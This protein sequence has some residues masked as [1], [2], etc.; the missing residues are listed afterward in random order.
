M[1]NDDI[2]AFEAEIEQVTG[3][4]SG[5]A[6]AGSKLP[7]LYGTDKTDE[8]NVD[9]P[10]I[11]DHPFNPFSG[12]HPAGDDVDDLQSFHKKYGRELQSFQ[13]ND[14][15]EMP[16]QSEL[17]LPEIPTPPAPFV[18]DKPPDSI[19]SLDEYNR[20]LF[21]PQAPRLEA[22]AEAQ[23]NFFSFK[24]RVED[25]EKAAIKKYSDGFPPYLETVDNFALPLMDREEK[26]KRLVLGNQNP[27]EAAYVLGICERF[28]HLVSEIVRRGG[29]ITRD[30]F[31][32]ARF[33]PGVQAARDDSR[34]ITY[35]SM[36]NEA[37]L[38]VLEDFK[39][40]EEGE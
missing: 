11:G 2:E 22:H 16:Q 15:R 28:P 12:T 8:E 29:K 34:L 32:G 20:W 13:H 37:F 18:P 3:I 6:L 30:L 9:L 1:T 5:G 39:A 10:E 38:K 26:F 35:D 14:T 27:A 25:T 40:S 7:D 31:Q 23:A 19:A 17:V 4:S 21:E 24:Q 36:S 33:R